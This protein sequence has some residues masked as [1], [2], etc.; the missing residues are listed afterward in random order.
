MGAFQLCV[1]D[2]LNDTT[3]AYAPGERYGL[4]V[5]GAPSEPGGRRGHAGPAWTT[6]V[7]HVAGGLKDSRLITAWVARL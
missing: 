4:D 6:L 3:R 2:V 1:A 5:L 7:G